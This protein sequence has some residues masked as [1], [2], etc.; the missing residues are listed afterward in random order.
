MSTPKDRYSWGKPKPQLTKHIYNWP[1]PKPQKY[2]WPKQP[3]KQPNHHPS[4]LAPYYWTYPQ[5]IKKHG[6]V[7][8]GAKA[9]V[10]NKK[11][12]LVYTKSHSYHHKPRGWNQSVYTNSIRKPSTQTNYLKR[13]N[14]PFSF[15]KYRTKFC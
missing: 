8:Y 2:N 3:F 14:K 5:H 10:K 6:H 11:E 13:S 12:T 15:R 9:P 1:K 4:R 7:M